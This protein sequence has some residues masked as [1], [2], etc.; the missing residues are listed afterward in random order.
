MESWTLLVEVIVLLASCLILGGVASRFGQNALV[1]YLLAGMIVGGPGSLR[2]IAGSD[3]IEAIAELGVTLLLFSL[4]LEFSW[5]R[6]A[7][8]GI[9]N[10]AAGAIQV[11]LTVVCGA[12]VAVW[13]GLSYGEAIAAGAMVSVSSTA[14]VLRVLQDRGE[15]DS[16]YGRN[17]IAILLVQDAAVV[18]LA[19]LVA[20][21]VGERTP[22]ETFSELGKVLFFIVAVALLFYVTLKKIAVR[23]LE[24]HA[25]TRNRDLAVLLAAVVGLGSSWVAHAVGLPPALGAFLAGLYLGGSPF[26]TQIRA[27]VSPFRIVLLTLFFGAVGMV[28]DPRWILSN[29]ALVLG[30]TAM[31]VAGKALIVWLVLRFVGQPNGVAAATGVALGQTG[32]FSFLLG[33]MGR[34]TGV[35]GET[36]YAAVVSSAIITLL[37]TPY[38]I[39]AAPRLGRRIELLGRRSGLA[40]LDTAKVEGPEVVIVGFGPAGR[41]VAEALVGTGTRVLVLD[42]NSRSARAA[43]ALGFVGHVGDAQRAEVLEHAGVSS[44]RV[45]VITLPA[46][47]AAVEVLR[48][49]RRLAPEAHVVSRSRYQLHRPDFESA[50][51]HAVVGDEEEVGRALAEHVLLQLGGDAQPSAPPP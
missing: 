42:L 49:V 32:E 36:T 29:W 46:R 21:L 24:S 34:E 30:L 4:G 22:Y 26:A 35:V 41:A 23:A 14:C 31:L 48:E 6:L 13:L 2:I 19:M 38:L 50:G 25:L 47:S 51:S 33:R 39:S 43:E 10:L 1:G 44:A 12:G 27:D 18:P 3:H 28:A 15:I 17:S 9:R 7:L 8:L 11:A 45:V 16:L 40:G 37:L 20:L 5:R